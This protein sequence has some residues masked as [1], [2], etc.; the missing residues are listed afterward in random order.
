MPD[1]DHKIV[2]W[3]ETPEVIKVLPSHM[4]ASFPAFASGVLLSL[5]RIET[6]PIPS[7]IEALVGSDNVTLIVSIDS[8]VASSIIEI[9][10]VLEVWPGAKVK[11]PFVE[12]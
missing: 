8:I 2:P 11:V 3:F 12:E 6:T 1:V 5:S 9:V 7:K 4:L 10:K